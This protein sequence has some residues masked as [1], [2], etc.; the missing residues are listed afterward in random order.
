MPHFVDSSSKGF[1][2]AADLAMGVAVK[3]GAT[4]GAV[5]VSTAATDKTIGFVTE[6][7]KAG[8][9][10]NVKLLDGNGTVPVVLGGTV[11]IGDTLVVTAAGAVITGTQAGAG[12]QPV[13]RA[14]GIALEAG[15]IGQ[16]IE[17]VPVSYPF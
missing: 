17:A 11:A 10:V 5:V 4:A 3:P 6:A 15:T 7:A 1:S 9:T 2:T 14:V 12:A 8:R 16:V 13:N